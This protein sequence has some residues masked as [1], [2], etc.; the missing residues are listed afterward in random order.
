MFDPQ[1]SEPI[2]FEWDE[3]NITKIRLKHGITPEEAEQPFFNDSWVE[4]DRL[5]S[6][7]EMRFRLLGKNNFGKVLFIIF[8]I[9]KLKIRIISARSADK[10]ERILYEQKIKKNS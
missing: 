1:F 4:L 7:A 10:K 2:I 9:R 8:T 3:F 5:H 6:S